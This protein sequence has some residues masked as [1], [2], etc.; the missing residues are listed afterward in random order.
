M[1]IFMSEADKRRKRRRAAAKEAT[2]RHIAK[3]N[4]RLEKET[5]E[6]A[7]R[8][9]DEINETLNTEYARTHFKK[10]MTLLKKR[11]YFENI[12]IGAMR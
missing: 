6:T 4:A 7:K 5:L 12:I 9:L 1:D 3:M 11:A 10:R 2:A 8:R